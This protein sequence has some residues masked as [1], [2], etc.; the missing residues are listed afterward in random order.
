MTQSVAHECATRR[1]PA[2]LAASAYDATPPVAL[3]RYAVHAIADDGRHPPSQLF[4]T[5][6][7]RVRVAHAASV[8]AG[9][10]NHASLLRG[11]VRVQPC[12]AILKTNNK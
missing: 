8:A 3:A 11:S 7:A 2:A 9:A 10:T 6:A 5:G 4:G 1:I 12:T